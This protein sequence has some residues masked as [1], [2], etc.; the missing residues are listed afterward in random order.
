MPCRDASRCG[1]GPPPRSALRR[2]RPPT[3]HCRDL[4]RPGSRHRPSR[5][6]P[7]RRRCLRC[8]ADVDM[9]RPGAE[10]GGVVDAAARAGT[11]DQHDVVEVDAVVRRGMG[12]RR[13]AVAVPDRRQVRVVVRTGRAQTVDGIGELAATVLRA[14]FCPGGAVGRPVRRVVPQPHHGSHRGTV[15]VV[16]RGLVHVDRLV[17]QPRSTGGV[18]VD[19]SACD[20]RPTRTGHCDV[21]PSLWRPCG[22]GISLPGRQPAFQTRCRGGEDARSP[23][24]TPPRRPRTQGVAVPTSR[25]HDGP[26]DQGELL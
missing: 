4:R 23:T 17:H 24:P 19:A 7:G 9:V 12:D 3:G 10:I 14:A 15:T 25:R 2:S 8:C 20:A 22:D 11:A 21:R 26:N 13:R 5:G 18:G 1:W 16:D 6:R